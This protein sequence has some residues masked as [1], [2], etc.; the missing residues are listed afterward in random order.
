MFQTCFWTSLTLITE[1]WILP[2]V[3]QSGMKIESN[4]KITLNWLSNITLLTSVELFFVLDGGKE[5]TSQ[6]FCLDR[7]FQ[8]I[9]LDAILADC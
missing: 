7:L 6:D 8:P 3:F 4:K 9:N 1:L 2:H 5:D